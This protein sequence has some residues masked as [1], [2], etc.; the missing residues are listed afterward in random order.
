MSPFKNF[1]SILFLNEL[2]YFAV[3]TTLQQIPFYWSWSILQHN[4]Q[5]FELS[6]ALQSHLMIC[7]ANC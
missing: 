6:Q 5:F 2:I 4:Q 3:A 1:I 7:P